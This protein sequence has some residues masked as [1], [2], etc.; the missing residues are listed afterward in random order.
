[1]FFKNVHVISYAVV[2]DL[3]DNLIWLLG[4]TPRAP[5][6]GPSK[7]QEGRK[8][9]EGACSWMDRVPSLTPHFQLMSLRF[10]KSRTHFSANESFTFWATENLPSEENAQWFQR[11]EN[12]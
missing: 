9:D 8:Q 10:K 5:F 3:K 7:M 4:F 11:T 12:H 6:R 1:M 2:K